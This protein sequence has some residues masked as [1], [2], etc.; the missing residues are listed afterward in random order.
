MLGCRQVGADNFTVL[1]MGE[2]LEVFKN[3]GDGS[4]AYND[5]NEVRFYYSEG[6]SFGFAKVGDSINRN[7]CDIESNNPESRLCF[8]TSGG[9]MNGGWRCGST[10]RL[11]GSSSWER[12]IFTRD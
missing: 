12:Y 2:N 6:A 9:N 4:R 11:N 8:H 1:A 10:I 3:V 5:H 7:S